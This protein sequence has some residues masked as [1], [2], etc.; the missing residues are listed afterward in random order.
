M[1]NR[2]D[3]AFTVELL[4]LF[5]LLIAVITV[6]SSVFVMSRAHSLQ[7]KQLTE[8]V[9]LAESAA[10]TAS[11]ASDNDKLLDAIADMDNSYDHAAVSNEN[12]ESDG[13]VV[14]A[15]ASIE[16]SDL[17]SDSDKYLIRVTRSYPDGT[18]DERADKGTYAQ[19]VIDIFEQGMVDPDQ[20]GNIDNSK[21]GEPL[22][23]LT[24]GTY[25]GNERQ[26]G[27]GGES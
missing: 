13:I 19:D 12:S 22:Y 5:I 1:R 15:L 24:A 9:I 14:F 7:A 6:I 18:D 16:R 2:R 26:G 20:L 21:L 11:A 10:E 25:F 4:G 3:T 23:T 27:E 8:A 17:S